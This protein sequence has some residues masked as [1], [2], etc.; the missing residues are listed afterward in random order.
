MVRIGLFLFA[1]AGVVGFFAIDFKVMLE[2]KP[3]LLNETVYADRPYILEG[4]LTGLSLARLVLISRHHKAPVTL[5]MT[6]PAQIVRL[7]SEVNPNTEFSDWTPMPVSAYVL[8]SNFEGNKNHLTF[9]VSKQFAAG[10]IVL[11]PGGPRLS[12]PVIVLSEGALSAH[13]VRTFNK[14]LGPLRDNDKKLLGAFFT[15]VL[16]ACILIIWSRLRTH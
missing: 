4:D 9:A 15:L 8:G 5:T 10:E 11:A 1:V 16:V 3:L 2:T 7:L 13:T 12:A 6:A 14:I